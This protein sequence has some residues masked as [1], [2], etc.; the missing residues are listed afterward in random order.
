M[1][2][3]AFASKVDWREMREFAGAD[4]T[5]SFVLFWE[6]E[7]KTLAIDIDLFLMPE[8]P[9]YEKPRPSEQAC[10]R[11]AVIE[12]PFCERIESEEIPAD[13]DP[14]TMVTKLDH[15]AIEDLRR[16]VDG[17]YELKGEFGVV[18]LNAERPILRLKGP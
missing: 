9:F 1:A 17:R 10:I 5:R 8:H 12:F 3:T 14:A 2:E 6:L 16:L 7:S 4:L 18:L 11:P 15:G 13:T